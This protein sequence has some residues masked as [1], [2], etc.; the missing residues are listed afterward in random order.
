MSET[1]NTLA[2]YTKSIKC[3]V[4]QAP[5]GVQ[6]A[7]SFDQLGIFMTFKQSFL[8]TAKELYYWVTLI[9]KVRLGK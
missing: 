3:F 8:I 1:T 9:L 5:E 6:G 4:V 2:Y 7:V